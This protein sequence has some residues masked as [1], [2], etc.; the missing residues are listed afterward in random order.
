MV[1]GTAGALEGNSTDA[2]M[3]RF[4]D[5]LLGQAEAQRS[6]GVAA[7][8][9]SVEAMQEEPGASSTDG[10]A[11]VTTQ[12]AGQQCAS[13]SGSPQPGQPPRSAAGPAGTSHSKVR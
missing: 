2:D 4:V 3:L 7:E 13:R 1:A 10:A 8:V 5:D 12:A 9:L 6:T 11:G